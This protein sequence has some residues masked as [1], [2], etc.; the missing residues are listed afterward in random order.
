MATFYKYKERDDISK[1]MID[2]SGITKEISDNLMKEKNRRDDLK[3]KLEEDQLNKIKAVEE[4]TQGLD[5]SMNQTM[6]KVSQQYKDYLLSSHKLMKSG[7]VSVN[8]TKIRKQGAIDTFNSIDDAAKNYNEKMSEIINTGGN[9]NEFFAKY[10][11]EALDIANSELVI[12]NMGRGT[13]IKLDEDGNEV[14][15]PAQGFATLLNTKYDRFDANSAFDNA[16]KNIAE[17]TIAKSGY[18]SVTDFRQKEKLYNEWL[19]NSTKYILNSDKKIAEVAA[20]LLHIDVVKDKYLAEEE[21]L[22]YSEWNGV[23]MTINTEFVKD[24]VKSA[25]QNGL[26]SRLD[27]IENRTPYRPTASEISSSAGK[28][29]DKEVSSLIEKFVVNADFSALKSALAQKGFSG[30]IAPD[31]NGIIKLINSSGESLDVQTKDRNAQQ[32][33]QEIAGFLKVGEY[34]K[35]RNITANLNTGVLTNKS[36]YGIFVSTPVKNFDTTENREYV[37]NKL[38][39]FS[40]AL[41]GE[42]RSK[43][44]AQRIQNIVGNKADITYD[45]DDVIINGDLKV[46]NGI[47]NAARVFSA[48]DNAK[49]ENKSNTQAP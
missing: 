13:F 16:T 35:D 32:V 11:A 31:K 21:G 24:K 19:E 23:K 39:D 4:F 43:E 37:Y 28:K 46:A 38:E 34:F 41:T 20:D 17:T 22:M 15:I 40:G 9:L 25:V 44:I 12:D 45:G 3:Q 33:G 30:S 18:F 6:M 8:D 48:I 7:F 26:N 2:W 27:H 5:P 29:V 36:D 47:N 49:T 1:S 14:A 42:E 10:A